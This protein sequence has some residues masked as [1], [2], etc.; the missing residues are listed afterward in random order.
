MLDDRYH[1]KLPSLNRVLQSAIEPCQ[2]LPNLTLN[3]QDYTIAQDLGSLGLLGRKDG[4]IASWEILCS[5][6]GLKFSGS[7]AWKQAC[8]IRCRYSCVRMVEITRM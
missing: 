8:L 6:A 2:K 4:T 1:R 7:A 3:F 5:V